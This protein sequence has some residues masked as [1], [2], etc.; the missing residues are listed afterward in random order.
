MIISIGGWACGWCAITIIIMCAYANER[1]HWFDLSS[2][3]KETAR[4]VICSIFQL[5]SDMVKCKSQHN[6]LN[7]WNISR[8]WRMRC[9]MNDI[10]KCSRWNNPFCYALLCFASLRIA[11]LFQVWYWSGCFLFHPFLAPF[12]L[13]P[14]PSFTLAELI[15]CSHTIIYNQKKV[16]DIV[17]RFIINISKLKRPHLSSSPPPPHIRSN[18]LGIFRKLQVSNARN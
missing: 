14:S 18:T 3:S 4:A 11:L 8:W 16:G 1:T 12:L 2:M 13:P 15:W 9:R 6:L 7:H 5:Q 17:H 10:S